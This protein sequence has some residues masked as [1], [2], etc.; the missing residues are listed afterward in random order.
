[1]RE[2]GAAILTAAQVERVEQV[3]HISMVYGSLNLDLESMSES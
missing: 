1:M 3:D 2:R